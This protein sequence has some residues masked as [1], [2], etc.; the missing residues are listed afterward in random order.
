[1]TR[2]TAQSAK[3]ALF[4]GLLFFVGVQLALNVFIERRHPEFYD[5]EYSARLR[6][7]RDRQAESPSRP[8]LGVM[9]SSRTEMGFRPEEVTNLSTSTA[10]SPLPF[11]LGHIGGGAIEELMLYKR[12]R[13]DG[14]RPA[15]LVL[16]IMPL[17]LSG[18]VS[19]FATEFM[20]ARDMPVL[21]RHI[22]PH[23]LYPRFAWPRLVP[24]HQNRL[25]IMRRIVP[26]GALAPQQDLEAIPLGPLGGDQGWFVKD[27]VAPEEYR[28]RLEGTR[29]YALFKLGRYA[30]NQ[31]A[32]HAYDELLTECRRDGIPVLLVLM[33]EGEQ[34]RS[35]Y[36]PEA[37]ARL[38]AWCGDL[39]RRHDVPIVDARRWLPE[40]DFM[41]SSHVLRRGATVFTRRFS[42]EA[43][44]PFV[45]GRLRGAGIH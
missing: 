2:P 32:T 15:W 30:V 39:S 35:L 19:T 20:T 14:V 33:P 31:R 27:S 11:N 22:E 37:M 18:N 24:L 7:V 41:D 29:S 8:L 38:D 42:E 26:D 1:M 9:G 4:S 43:L 17:F 25:E 5:F 28:R 21:Y 12:Y 36:P 6:R 23:K 44:L 40:E 16:E 13:R 45:E 3:V 10:G 34:L